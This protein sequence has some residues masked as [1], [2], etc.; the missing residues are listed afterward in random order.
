[1]PRAGLSPPTRGIHGHVGAAIAL[2]RSIPAYAGDP[3]SHSSGDTSGGLSPLQAG[4][5]R[6]ATL[7]SVRIRSIRDVQSLSRFSGLSPPTM[8]S[9]PAYAGDPDGAIPATRGICAGG[10][11]P[12]YG[13]LSPPTRG[14]R[15]LMMHGGS[16]PAYAGDPP[17][18][19]AIAVYPRL[20]S[21]RGLFGGLKRGYARGIPRRTRV[22]PR[23]R[24]GSPTSFDILAL[25]LS[26][27]WMFI[28]QLCPA[29]RRHATAAVAPLG[30]FNQVNPVRVH[31]L[32]GG[33]A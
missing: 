28:G 6:R 31:Y 29:K 16:I 12:R 14:I 25:P 20:P 27:N 4:D 15:A 22:Y 30:V 26:Q 23:L 33:F 8:R 32:F 10:L 11:R 13:G 7:I 19:G 3:C 9:I 24:G 17:P 2:A 5:L 18:S 1:M 21:R